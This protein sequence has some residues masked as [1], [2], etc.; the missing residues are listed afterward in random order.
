MSVGRSINIISDSKLV[1]EVA[2]PQHSES[3]ILQLQMGARLHQQ[4][5]SLQYVSY[6]CNMYHILYDTYCM[7]TVK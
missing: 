1:T 7:S 5:S 6:E 2:L 3:M 4:E